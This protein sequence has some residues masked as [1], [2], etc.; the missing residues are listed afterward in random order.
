ME[1]VLVLVVLFV[2][3]GIHAGLGFGTA[4]VAMPF[5]TVLVGLPVAAPLVALVMTVTIGLSLMSN[6]QHADYRSA[7]TFLGFS[8][9]G[10]P[11]GALLIR[12]VNVTVGQGVL[13]GVLLCFSLF[14]L[15]NVE[16][17]LRDTTAWRAVAGFLGGCLGVA[18]NTNAPPVV[19]YG[20]LVRWP[21]EQFRGTLQGFFLPSSVMICATH[22][23]FGLWTR[24]V[25]LLFALAIPVIV[26]AS[27]VG[28]RLSR[29]LSR[30]GFERLIYVFSG[31]MGAA[32]VARALV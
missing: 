8:L 26:L 27:I 24:E 3:V 31:I 1:I 32:L 5:L 4:L 25:L 14:R 16:I 7:L 23:G 12:E 17:Q 30:I 22:A 20:A 10:M 13:G 18:Y 6:W 29:R 11:L 9:L 15:A 21:P 2:A 28:R 19:V